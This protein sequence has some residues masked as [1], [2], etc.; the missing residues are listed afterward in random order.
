MSFPG[1]HHVGRSDSFDQLTDEG[2]EH[3]LYVCFNVTS[4]FN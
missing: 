2:K 3:G 1:K 4:N